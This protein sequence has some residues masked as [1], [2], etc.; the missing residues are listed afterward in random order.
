EL[1]KARALT[2]AGVR[3]SGSSPSSLKSVAGKLRWLAVGSVV[4]ISG[5]AE[6]AEPAAAWATL[7]GYFEPEREGL[8][9]RMTSIDAIVMN[10]ILVDEG[11]YLFDRK[12]GMLL[13]KGD[14]FSGEGPREANNYQ[15]VGYFRQWGQSDV[16]YRHDE[17]THW[18]YV[19]QRNPDNNKWQLH[20]HA[21]DS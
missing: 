12:I 14:I 16:F 3:V 9:A 6:A 7:T 8:S 18:T 10:L 19:L 13:S 21:P 11:K 17:E 5:I 20:S 4:V 15:V 2:R 1:A